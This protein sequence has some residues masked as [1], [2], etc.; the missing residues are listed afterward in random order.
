MFLDEI[1]CWLSAESVFSILN[2]EYLCENETKFENIL[3]PLVS[4]PDQFEL[5]KKTGGQKSCWTVPLM[6]SSRYIDYNNYLVSVL[7]V[8]LITITT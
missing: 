6:N 3:T 4:G 8:M 7:G 1:F 5:W 2:F